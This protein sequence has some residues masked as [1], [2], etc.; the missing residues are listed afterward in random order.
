MKKKTLLLIPMSVFALLFLSGC[1]G[2][3]LFNPENFAFTDPIWWVSQFF[4]LI[5]LVCFIWCFQ[6]RNKIKMM[7]ITGIGCLAFSLSALFISFSGVGGINNL[8]IMALFFLAAVRNFLFAYFDWRI[9]K[10]KRMDKWLYYFFCGFFIVATILSTILLY[11]FGFGT[12]LWLEI[13]ICTTLVGLIVGNILKGTNVMRISFII[14]RVF[15][16]I[17][18]IYVGNLIGLIIAACAI[19]SNIVYY[20][21]LFIDIK[22]GRLKKNYF[23]SDD[24]VSND[25]VKENVGCVE[26][27]TVLVEAE[28]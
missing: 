23:L 28:K 6:I 17:N 19:T 2:T 15:T 5:C 21:K 8:T 3:S 11:L 25:A 22:K 4:A 18:H 16:I 26:E 1:E 10:G 24:D 27:T 13:V 14:N 12:M 20:I 7:V 9:S